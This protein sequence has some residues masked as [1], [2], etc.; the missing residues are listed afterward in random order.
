MNNG[1]EEDKK[2]AVLDAPLPTEA[3]P[4]Q[5][6]EKA[7]ELILAKGGASLPARDTLDQRII[8]EVK[9]RTGRI[10]DVQ[11]GYPHGTEYE[12]T[13]NAWPTLKSL[14]APADTDKDGMPDA[15]E[16]K[17]GLNAADPGDASAYKLSKSYTNIEVYVN[18]I[19]K[20]DR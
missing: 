19:T 16:K 20:A 6:A 10:I 9:N 13:I 14:A 8:N 15:W 12:Q 5:S 17:H 4:D 7:Y 18:D 2:A 1:T 3:I 11:G